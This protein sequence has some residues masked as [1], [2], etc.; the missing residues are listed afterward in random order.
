MIDEVEAAGE[1]EESDGVFPIVT[2]ETGQYFD[3]RRRTEF[4][5]RGNVSGRAVQG[6]L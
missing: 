4:A 3:N 6:A 5:G 2:S 1:D